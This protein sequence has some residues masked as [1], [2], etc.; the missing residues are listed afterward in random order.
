MTQQQF[1]GQRGEQLAVAYLEKN[2][3]QI[4]ARNWH[5]Q[6]GELDIIARQA[7]TLVFIEVKTRHSQTT[8]DSFA[9]ITPGKRKR[10]IATARMYLH[11]TEQ[12]DMMWRIDAIGIALNSDQK[13]VIDHVEDA[14]E[15]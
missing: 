5:C 10:L 8:Q 3:Y 13:P 4:I 1:T 2:G 11:E 6:Y 15:W 9:A 12:D 14:L 7:Q